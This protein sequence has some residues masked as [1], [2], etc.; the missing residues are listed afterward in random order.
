M[1]KRTL[2]HIAIPLLCPQGP[3]SLQ[4]KIDLQRFRVYACTSIQIYLVPDSIT[5]SC[6][7]HHTFCLDFSNDLCGARALAAQRSGSVAS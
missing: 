6:F 2:T 3:V 7:Q 4:K 1:Y 5:M